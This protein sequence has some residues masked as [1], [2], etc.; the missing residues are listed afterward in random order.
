MNIIEEPIR[1]IK[2]S[3][4]IEE[5]PRIPQFFR[6]ELKTAYSR[7]EHFIGIRFGDFEEAEI[8]EDRQKYPHLLFPDRDGL[9]VFCQYRCVAYMHRKSG[10]DYKYCAVQMYEQYLDYV[11][12]GYVQ[13]VEREQIEGEYLLT[14][15]M[16]EEFS[17]KTKRN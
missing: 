1:T 9:P 5:L 6:S 8:E 16:I 17:N 2:E 12:A 13:G 4:P 10:I 7:Y 11:A 15:S 14:L 3:A